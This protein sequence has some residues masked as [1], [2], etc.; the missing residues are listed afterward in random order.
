MLNEGLHVEDISG[1]IMARPTDSRIIYL[2]QLGR[3]LSSDTSRDKTIVFDLVNNYLKN[4]L[5]AEINRRTNGSKTIN[6]GEAGIGDGEDTE[7]EDIDIFRIQG[8]TKEFLELLNEIQDITGHT[9]ALISARKIKEW[10]E[11]NATTK[12]PATN[13]SN[14][15]EKM[16]ALALRNIR[17]TLVNPY[18]KLQSSEEKINFKLNILN[19]KKYCKL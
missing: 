7:I 16:L 12:P 4:N 1:V 5:D 2:Q 8:E 3:A 13:S 9:P 17:V 19:C 6:G 10:M 14:Y 15:E 18:S 11:R